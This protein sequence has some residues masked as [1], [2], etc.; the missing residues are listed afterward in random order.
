[1]TRAHRHAQRTHGQRQQREGHRTGALQ[2][3]REHAQSPERDAATRVE[4]YANHAST[5]P[6]RNGC[7]SQ[8]TCPFVHPYPAQSAPPLRALGEERPPFAPA[9]GGCLV[10]VLAPG[11]L[12]ASPALD[13]RLA[14]DLLLLLP[15]LAQ[16]L[17]QPGGTVPTTWFC[18]LP[19]GS[20]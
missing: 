4:E 8:R 15:K 16:A 14:P 6:A 1:M 2:Q 17:L 20:G 9:L 5:P 3:D 10:E 12:M 18:Y 11:K 13:R 19:Y 7:R